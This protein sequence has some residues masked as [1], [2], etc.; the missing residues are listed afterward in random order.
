MRILLIRHGDPDYVHDTLT[1]PGKVE[2]DLLAGRLVKETISAFYVSPLGRA[3]RTA[4]PTLEALGRTAVEKPWLEE[5][6]AKLQVDG[7][8]F[9]Q[10]SFPDTRKRPDGSFRPRICW[11]MVP[12]AWR[13]DPA[14][15]GKESWRETVVAEHSRMAQE[16][17][18]I[19]SGLD[20]LLAEYGYIRD[21]GLYRTQEG[22]MDTIVL[23]C[24]FGVSCV[25]LSHLLGISPHILLHSLCLA[26]TS[27]TEIY[28]EERQKGIV[29]F[30]VTKIGDI[31]HLYAGD[32]KPSFAA[33]FCE[34]YE[35]GWERH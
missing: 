17:D 35:N 13:N 16:Y 24:H 25:M 10:A 20:E 2:A 15:Y 22:R 12:A 34:V 8:E 18:R 31:S 27:V 6:D 4:R 5:F 28:S 23:F 30:R 26:P 32:T 14:Y 19:C 33:R 9:L 29:T 7:S 21:G 1:S 3:K 11:D